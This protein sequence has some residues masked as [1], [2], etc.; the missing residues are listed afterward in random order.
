MNTAFVF[1]GQGSQAVGMGKELYEKFSV[2]KEV[3]TKID[4]VLEQNLSEVIFEG[5]IEDLT[6]TQ[7]TQPALMATS[8]AFLSVILAES[9]K[10]IEDLCKFT[11]G[12]SVGEYA[13]LAAAGA[14]SVED[15]ARILRIRGNAM[16]ESCPKG[17]GAM[18]AV[19]G[20]SVEKV[21]EIVL[22]GNN[23]GICDIANDNSSSQIVLSGDIA[24]I[25]SAIEK[26]KEA[27]GKGIKLNV[28]GPFH[29]RL[30]AKA[31]AT[32]KN[33]LES[34]DIKAPIIPVILNVTA[35]ESIKAE[36]IRDSLVAQVAGRVRWRETISYMAENGIS[37][38]VEI[39]S[40]KVLNGML[41][42]EQHNFE[43]VN[44]GNIPEL[45]EF[46]KSIA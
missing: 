2:A 26:V 35:G 18:A 13:A 45:E 43:L 5:P 24:G 40:G 33:E 9:G 4:N 46:L 1:P 20:L 25:D 44:V 36:E 37:R 16:Q 42:R 21:E 39:G 38:I 22:E 10:K 19:L 27:G 6:L 15:A 7:N 12:H 31:E 29:S 34:V 23:S 14:L 11:A 28:S 8:M 3:F 32:M 17:E 41:K 30:M